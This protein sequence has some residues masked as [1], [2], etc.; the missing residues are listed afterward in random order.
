MSKAG[1]KLAAEVLGKAGARA[2]L[3]GGCVRDEI[4]GREPKDFD[5]EVFGADIATIKAALAPHFKLSEVG[6]SFGVLKAVPKVSAAGD[7]GADDAIDVSLP[8]RETKLGLGHRAFAMHFDPSLS[9]HEAAARRDF[10]INAIYKDPLTGEILDP[11][12]GL[13][14]LKNSVLRHVSSHFCEDPLR[15]L[16]AMQFIARFDLAAERETLEIC[17]GMTPE[18][19]PPERLFEEWRK[20]LIKGVKISRG[21]EFLRE[22]GW[23][24][25]YPELKALIGCEQAPQWHPEGDV[26]NHTLC[27]LD[28]FAASRDERGLD[29]NE[30]LIVGLAV[31]CH[32]FGKPGT[33]FFDKRLGRI[34]ALGH[35]E[36]GVKPTRAFLRRLTNE[37]RILKEVPPLVRLHMRPYAMWKSSSGEAAVRR[38]AAEVG[39]ID[40]LVQV[41]AADDAGRP[42]FPSQPDALVWLEKEAERLAV[43]DA[44]PKPLL[45]GRHLIALGLEPGT[46]FG[47]ILETAYNA[48]LDGKT[49]FLASGMIFERESDRWAMRKIDASSVYI[50]WDWNGTLLDDTRAALATLNIMLA[51]RGVKPIEKQFYLDNFA[52]PVR[53]FYERIGMV[54]E[55]EDWD[56]LAQEYHDLYHAQPK[57]LN[58]NALAAV[59]ET[60]A[61]GA[62]QSIISALRQDLLE[63]DTSRFGIRHYFEQVAGVDNLDGATKLE[64]ARVLLAELR[65]KHPFISHFVMIG[66]A[67][68][69]KE[70]ADSL[71]LEC[72]LCGE[73]SHAAWR[74]EKVA[75]TGSDLLSAALL[76]LESAAQAPANKARFANF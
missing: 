74:L 31:L 25:Y 7:S 15:V 14:D 41:C 6:I 46:A 30:A 1:A 48:Q 23:V 69:D 39:R 35:D 71:G 54:L 24:D 4:L 13:A 59:R 16:R 47:K 29:E 52:F 44:A 38:L 43:K 61:A 42:P 49:R 10:T 56:A 55:N 60:A 62:K 57:Q 20:L 68:H 63:R 32:D 70:V 2:L 18:G 17:R 9:L 76:A 58:R 11:W 22:S 51:R 8:R 5:L 53:P 33:S 28:A 72:V 73:G 64:R 3:V 19:L 65:K 26:W 27:S 45:M 34:R 37:E 36:A 12:G 67:L 66:D 40:R 50:L 21:L 75:R